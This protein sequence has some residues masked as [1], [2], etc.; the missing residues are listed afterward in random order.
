ML[1]LGQEARESP[2]RHLLYLCLRSRWDPGA[3][4]ALRE[5][6]SQCDGCWEQVAVL[7]REEF[8]VPLLYH[9]LHREGLVPPPL[10][11]EWRS[12]YHASILRSTRLSHQLEQVL[13][14]LAQVD[15]PVLLL[16]GAALAK[17]AYGD[18]ALRPMV[19][20][21]LLIPASRVDLAQGILE[22]LGYIP[23]T[24]DPW[25]GFSQRYRNSRAYGRGSG[26]PLPWMIGLHWHLFD[27]PYYQRIR[28]EEWFGRAQSACIAD[29][30]ALVPSPEDHLVYLCGH[31]ALHH[32]YDPALI[33]YCDM[34][35]LLHSVGG[36][37]D[38]DTLLRRATEWRLVIPLQRSLAR[39][40]ELWA[41]TVPAGVTRAAGQLRPTRAEQAVHRW[42]ADRPRTPTSDT[43]L[44]VATL[45]GLRRRAR[46]L[47]EATFPSPAYMRRRYCPEQ[48][49]LWPLAYLLRGGTAVRYLVQRLS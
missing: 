9:T 14:R 8:L 42:V 49:G 17:T 48:P 24:S 11:E 45:P 39:L 35:A 5:L 30:D 16:K 28:I 27:V 44:A 4:Q 3:S 21:D 34:A 36:G 31:L 15:C 1:D 22:K 12:V 10:E 29:M 20:L 13:R 26:R 47:L 43:L 19:D 7:A 46:F 2:A 41:D 6:A 38:W 18:T 40:E 37:L 32:Q 33:R 23:L 25:P